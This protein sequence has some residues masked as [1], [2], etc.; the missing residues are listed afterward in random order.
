[1][2]I[3]VLSSSDINLLFSHTHTQVEQSV[4]EVIFCIQCECSNFDLCVHGFMEVMF[5]VTGFSGTFV[6]WAQVKI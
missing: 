6:F 5:L 3:S 1:M 4:G 2:F